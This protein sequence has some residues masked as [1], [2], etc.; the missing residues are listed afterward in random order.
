GD[1]AKGQAR[2]PER[3]RIGA[4]VVVDAGGWALKYGVAGDDAPSVVTPSAVG[5]DGGK[6]E[7]K[8]LAAGRSALAAYGEAVQVKEVVQDGRVAHWAG[9]EALLRYAEEAVFGEDADRV[10]RRFMLVESL[11]AASEDRERMAE[12]YFEKFGA[13]SLFA[14]KSAPLNLYACARSSGLVLDIGGDR[15]SS[16]VVVDGFVHRDSI[17]FSQVA[18]KKVAETLLDRLETGAA[19][20]PGINVRPRYTFVRKTERDGSPKIAIQEAPAHASFAR[21]WKLDLVDQMIHARA[22][23]APVDPQALARVSRPTQSNTDE[24]VSSATIPEEDEDTYELPDGTLVPRA[25]RAAR[26]ALEILFNPKSLGRPETNVPVQEIVVKSAQFM[27]NADSRRDMYSNIVLA[28]GVT[29]TP[30]FADRV[31]CE[32]AVRARGAKPRIIVSGQEA[33]K[34]NAWIGGSIFSSLTALENL[35][36]SKSEYAE[37]GAKVINHKCP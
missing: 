28:G 33:R 5:V 18:G 26:D 10:E 6:G 24:L 22:R 9:F 15:S 3:E 31:A 1:G 23:A 36:V 8:G 14:C 17:K 12:I 27:T 2:A 19:D 13:T 32:I 16:C 30:G 7:P 25:A 37:Q 20:K 34:H 21:F 29:A 35:W 4:T 11:D